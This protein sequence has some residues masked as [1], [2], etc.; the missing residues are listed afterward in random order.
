MIIDMYL[1]NTLNNFYVIDC[2]FIY[3]HLFKDVS[4]E[5]ESTGGHLVFLK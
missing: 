2:L 3:Q 1:Y 5:N 4:L